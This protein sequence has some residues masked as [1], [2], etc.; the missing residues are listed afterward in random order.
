MATVTSVN[1]GNHLTVRKRRIERAVLKARYGIVGDAH[2]GNWHR[3]LCLLPVEG[4]RRTRRNWR[5][6]LEYGTFFENVDTLG[7][8]YSGMKVGDR[9][10]LGSSVI[11]I[12]QIG[13]PEA[14]HVGDRSAPVRSRSFADYLLE[15]EAVYAIVIEDGEVCPGD[16]IEVLSA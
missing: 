1:I 13:E 16:G 4:V 5:A 10:R 7:V 8:D 6:K 12:T 9:L 15:R 14:V 3:Q 2:A 11:E